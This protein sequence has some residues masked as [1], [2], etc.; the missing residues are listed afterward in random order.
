MPHLDKI[1][2]EGDAASLSFIF[3]HL[4]ITEGASVELRCEGRATQHISEIFPII[5]EQY[6][7]WLRS[8]PITCH[9]NFYGGPSHHL[10]PRV[11][12]SVWPT[13]AITSSRVVTPDPYDSYATRP[14]SI[15]LIIRGMNGRAL[16]QE[17]LRD[18]MPFCR[19]TRLHAISNRHIAPAHLHIF[20]YMPQVESLYIS[21]WESDTFDDPHESHMKLRIILGILLHSTRAVLEG[22]RP[23]DSLLLPK[24]QSLDIALEDAGIWHR[25][26]NDSSV[27]EPLTDKLRQLLVARAALGV[28]LRSISM[29][30]GSLQ[31][32]KYTPRWKGDEPCRIP[33]VTIPVEVRELLEDWN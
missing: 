12:V 6:S 4:R 31:A 32:A 1:G 19:A 7:S 29:V 20:P 14:S 16:V 15:L 24:L 10:D 18:V 33:P 13:P 8:I 11:H 27:D 2:L 25:R 28:P 22:R 21:R 17:L 3:R 26:D 9:I 23:R 30:E 5:N